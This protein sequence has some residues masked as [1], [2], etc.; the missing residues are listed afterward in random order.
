MRI[1]TREYKVF[2]IDELSEKAKD[3]A[4]SKW[5]EENEYPMADDN[6]H[7][8]ESFCKIFNIQAKEWEYGYRKYL[9][10]GFKED[11]DEH[12]DIARYKLTGV[13]LLKWIINNH[14]NDLFKPKYYSKWKSVANGNSQLISMKSKI[15]K[16]NDCV[17]TGYGMDYDIMQPILNFL[18]KPDEYTTLE[19][20][21]NRCLDA[22]LNACH[23]D[24]EDY[25]TMETFIEES[26]ANEW[27]YLEDGRMF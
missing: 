23:R 15:I 18:K 20:L 1:E 9:R 21:M 8:L 10:W 22:W 4:Y 3:K 26:Q 24:Y 2:T 13:R 11:Y 12:I 25:F 14:Y 7:T 19:N 5:Y 16:N 6:I 17:F 27:E